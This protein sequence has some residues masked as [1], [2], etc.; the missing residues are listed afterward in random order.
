MPD[1]KLIYKDLGNN[2]GMFD[3]G[4]AKHDLG[5]DEGLYTAVVVS[6]FT[7]RRAENDDILPG[8]D[9]RRGWWGDS[10]AE[11]D[12]DKI[13]SRLWLLSREKQ[14]Q[15]VLNRAREY[16][17]EAL[18]WFIEDGIAKQV[19]VDAWVPRQGVLGLGVQII[20]PDGSKLDFKFDNLWEA[21]N[22]VSAS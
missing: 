2:L 17:Q 14:L 12:G 9:D 3:V 5:T 15:S 22:A 4:L 10:F 8:G 20:R 7:D 21:M 1:I 16:A 11:I 19:I 18:Q 13:G 6:L